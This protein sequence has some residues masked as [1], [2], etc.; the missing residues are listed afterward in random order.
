MSYADGSAGVTEGKTPGLLDQ[1]CAR[2]RVKHYSLRTEQAYVGWT[3]RFIL[4]NG[5][6]HPWD[7][8]AAEIV[9]FLST[10]GDCLSG[11]FQVSS[12]A[13]YATS[14]MPASVNNFCS[15]AISFP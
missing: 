9:G 3:G 5:K 1:V 2:L 6:C 7:M 4:A 8:R 10:S 15:S 12:F 11:G 13:N 14:S